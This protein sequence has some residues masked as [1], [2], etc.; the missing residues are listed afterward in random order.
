H[1][2]G[3]WQVGDE[4]SMAAP[5]AILRL[6]RRHVQALGDQLERKIIEQRAVVQQMLAPT[7][8]RIARKLSF[9]PN[10]IANAAILDARRQ[11]RERRAQ[12]PHYFAMTNVDR[13]Q[14]RP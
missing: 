4:L 1:R 12:G 2:A 5:L 13:P 10:K 9:L 8:H 7:A 6:P 3:Q 14:M 11:L